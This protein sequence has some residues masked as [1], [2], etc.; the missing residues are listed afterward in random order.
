MSAAIAHPTPVGA[1]ARP[2]SFWASLVAVGAAAAALL[3][4]FVVTM[5]AVR[6]STG[7]GTGSTGQHTGTGNYNQLC[8]P[9]PSTRYC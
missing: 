4:W 8:V 1:T 3:I 9:A 6:S 2:L 7:T 5:S